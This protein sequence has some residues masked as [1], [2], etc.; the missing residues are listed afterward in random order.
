MS[1]PKNQISKCQTVSVF[2]IEYELLVGDGVTV[3]SYV[4]CFNIGPTH[5]ILLEVKPRCQDS[6]RRFALRQAQMS[7]RFAWCQRTYVW[8]AQGRQSGQQWAWCQA[9]P[10]VLGHSMYVS[11]CMYVC[12]RCKILLSFLPRYVFS[13]FNNHVIY[14]KQTNVWQLCPSTLGNKSHSG[15]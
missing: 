6:T 10:D 2:E 7:R 5:L 12:T 3:M 14:S 4:K 1:H 13:C 9:K 11:F 15:S 8:H